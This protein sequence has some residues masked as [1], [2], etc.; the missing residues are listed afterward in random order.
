[1]W[2]LDGKTSAHLTNHEPFV[3][4]IASHTTAFG[5]PVALFEGDSH[6][7]RSDDP[8]QEGA[9]CTG[10]DGVCGYDDWNSHPYEL[11]TGFGLVRHADG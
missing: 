10:D 5:K 6:T 7:Y 3:S 2:D 1:M 4:S 8:L 9:P 11:I